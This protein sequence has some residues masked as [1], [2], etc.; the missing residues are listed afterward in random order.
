MLLDWRNIVAAQAALAGPAG[1][2]VVA[3]W[4]AA[5]L[6]GIGGLLGRNDFTLE[7]VVWFDAIMPRRG[8]VAATGSPARDTAGV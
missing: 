1:S 2:H 6:P 7:R 5:H 8:R 3:I 4:G